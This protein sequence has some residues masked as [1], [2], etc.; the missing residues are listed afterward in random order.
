MIY[1]SLLRL[2]FNNFIKILPTIYLEEMFYQIGRML[3]VRSFTCERDLGLFEG[4]IN[5]N[6]VHRY[7]LR[8]GSWAPSLQYLISTLFANGPGTFIDVGANIGLTTIPVAQNND[9]LS[10]YAFEPESNN[11]SYLR[12]NIIANGLESK[13][14]T[15]N[16]ALFSEDCTLDMELSTD[17]M[18]DHRIRRQSVANS[19]GNYYNEQSR[20]TVKIQARKL[21]SILNVHDLIKP[22]IMKVDTQ[23]AEVRV[24]SGAKSFLEAV[25][26]L[27]VE[28]WPYGLRRMGDTTESLF[29]IISQFHWGAVYDD[30]VLSMPKLAPIK[31]FLAHIN[32]Y[33][34]KTGVGH[35]DILLAR[36]PMPH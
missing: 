3:G 7:Y 29:A 34:D 23:G 20:P 32:A 27:I 18:G 1:G 22:I 4:S 30:A 28:Y 16:L 35:L 13:I 21:D 11:Y 5:D 24:F 10:F 25:D 12:K 26:Y 31:Q 19:Q 33:L 8:H 15:F 6:A 14:K 9:K 36:H 17:N 2:F